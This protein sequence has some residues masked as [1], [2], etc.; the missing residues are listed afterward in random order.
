VCCFGDLFDLEAVA[1]IHFGPTGCC[2]AGRFGGRN[3][4]RRL[5]HI[6]AARPLAERSHACY[7][8]KGPRSAERPSDH[9]P[10]VAEFED[11]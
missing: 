7:I 2:W 10:I 5:D 1:R 3:L 6:M 8:D 9:T 11:V 4:G